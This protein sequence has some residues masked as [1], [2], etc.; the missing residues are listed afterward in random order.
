MTDKQ[1]G[2]RLPA[3][4]AQGQAPGLGELLGGLADLNVEVTLELGRSKI[5]L[6]QARQLGE[7]ALLEV[8]AGHS[9]GFVVSGARDKHSLWPAS[10]SHL[11]ARGRPQRGICRERSEGQTDRK[12]TRLNSSHN[13]ES[14]MPSS[15]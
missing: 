10:P 12:S 2:K 13:R 8:G 14:R 11:P 4:P 7:N 3:V 5:S 9:E 15:A 6:E 1:N